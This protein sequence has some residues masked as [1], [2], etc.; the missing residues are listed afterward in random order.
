MI[1]LLPRVRKS[2]TSR[3]LTAAEERFHSGTRS[4]ADVV[5]PAG[6]DAARSH[7]LLDGRYLRILGLAEYPRYVYAN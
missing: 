7:L 6:L 3:R 2:G 5:S 1:R 4:V